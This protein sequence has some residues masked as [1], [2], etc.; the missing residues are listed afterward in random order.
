MRGIGRELPYTEYGP[1]DLVE[2]AILSRSWK[3]FDPFEKRG[4]ACQFKR[5]SPGDGHVDRSTADVIG[6]KRS[7]VGH[8]EKFHHFHGAFPRVARV[9]VI[10]LDAKTAA[11]RNLRRL[12]VPVPDEPGVVHEEC[13]SRIASRARHEDR[14]SG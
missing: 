1:G 10:P 11:L 8:V 12:N 2:L 4:R 3:T 7:V 5:P 6:H 14:G 13:T 9:A